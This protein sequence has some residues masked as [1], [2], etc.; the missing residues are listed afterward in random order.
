MSTTFIKLFCSI[1]N[2]LVEVVRKSNW[3]YVILIFEFRFSQNEG[4]IS[5]TKAWKVSILNVHFYAQNNLSI[6]FSCIEVLMDQ[7]SQTKV[8]FAPSVFSNYFFPEPPAGFFPTSLNWK[9]R[10]CWRL[11]DRIIPSVAPA[12]KSWDDV[13]AKM[14]LV[15]LTSLS[16]IIFTHSHQPPHAFLPSTS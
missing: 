6:S 11:F 16:D 3:F 2:L 10:I 1:W 5:S 9:L 7:K 12:R 14:I 8:I 13:N 15:C 4:L